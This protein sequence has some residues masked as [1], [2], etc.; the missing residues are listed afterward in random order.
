MF[1]LSGVCQTTSSLSL[2]GRAGLCGAAWRPQSFPHT[3]PDVAPSW[4][5]NAA[6]TRFYMVMYVSGGESVLS[7]YLAWISRFCDM[8]LF[9]ADGSSPVPRT[10]MISTQRKA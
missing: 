5:E 1:A 4:L 10:S 3:P 7:V 6:S 2:E 9:S 8:L